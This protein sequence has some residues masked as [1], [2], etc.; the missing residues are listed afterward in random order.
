VRA[1]HVPDEVVEVLASGDTTEM[2]TPGGPEDA[3][4]EGGS[5]ERNKE[6]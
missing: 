4:A 1:R 6:R 3:E 2:P 5:A